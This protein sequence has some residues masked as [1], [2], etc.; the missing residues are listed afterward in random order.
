MKLHKEIYQYFMVNLICSKTFWYLWYDFPITFHIVIGDIPHLWNF[1]LVTCVRMPRASLSKAFPSETSSPSF[2]FVPLLS[3]HTH[4]TAQWYNIML[5]I[6]LSRRRF[7]QSKTAIAANSSTTYFPL[8]TILSVWDRRT[9]WACSP[10][11]RLPG[12]FEVFNLNVSRT[13]SSGLPSF[14]PSAL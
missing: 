4:E 12:S 14:P 8:C 6:S 7:S 1:P 11:F 9:C 10:T 3:A 5:I 13:M 2:Y